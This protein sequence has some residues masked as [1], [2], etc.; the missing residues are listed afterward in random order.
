MKEVKKKINPIEKVIVYR[1]KS[2]RSEK[3]IKEQ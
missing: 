3:E 2:N 1:K